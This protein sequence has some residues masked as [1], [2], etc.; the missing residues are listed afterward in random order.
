MRKYIP[1]TIVIVALFAGFLTVLSYAAS[2]PDQGQTWGTPCNGLSISA[3]PVKTE[4]KLTDSIEVKIDAKNVGTEPILLFADGGPFS[5]YRMAL[6]HE[7]GRPVALTDRASST[8]QWPESN[9]SVPVEN[10]ALDKIIGKNVTLG[11]I[12]IE[13]A[14]AQVE[15]HPVRKTFQ[16]SPGQTLDAPDSVTLGDWF[17]IDSAGTYT[18]VVMRRSNS[19]NT[20]FSVSNAAK[21]VITK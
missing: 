16:L 21:I 1:V 18:L 7:D 11:D 12:K 8:L 5:Y 17:K 3:N 20:G 4:Y 2:Q 6:F 10:P 13:D 9:L 15:Q 14:P 19:W